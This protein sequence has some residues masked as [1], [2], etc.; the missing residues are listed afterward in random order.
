MDLTTL[1]VI[2]GGLLLLVLLS[3]QTARRLALAVAFIAILLAAKQVF[4][5]G[6]SCDATGLPCQQLLMNTT[7]A[8]WCWASS[9]DASVLRRDG[10]YFLV[11]D[12]SNR[13]R[14]RGQC[15]DVRF[16]RDRRT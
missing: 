1:V 4:V 16:W 6:A 11:A 14:V 8:G 5:H 7:F 13:S 3:N 15:F 12:G 10:Q 2:A 9:D